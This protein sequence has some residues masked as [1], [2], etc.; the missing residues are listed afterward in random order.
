[1]TTDRLLRDRPWLLASLLIV[2]TFVAYQP[3]WHAGFV[4]DDD[5]WTT[6]ISVLLRDFS[7]LRRMWCQLSALQQYYPLSGTTFWLDYH[8]WSF[9]PLPYHLENVLLHAFAALLFWVLLRRLQSP[10]AWFAA[11]IFA[12]HP[13]MVES[14]AWVTERKNVLSLVLYLGAL[15]AYGRFTRFWNDEHNCAS[16]TEGVS[17]R[18]W[19]AY[20]L[21]LTLFSAAMLAKVTAFSLPPVLLL[22]G[23]WKRGRI[24]WREDV[25]PVLPFLALA[26]GLGL[27]I[28][29]LEWHQVGAIGSEWAIPFPERC[30]IA[31][32][33]F[34]F[35][36]GKLVWP[37]NL[38]FVYPRWE[39]DAGSWKQW[40]YPITAGATL[41]ALW[42]ARKRIGRGPAAAAL[43]FV[44]TLFPVLGFL[45]VYFMRFSFV[46]DHWTYLPSLG[47]IALAGALVARAAERCRVP[48]ALEGFAVVVLPVLA[49]LTWSQGHIYHDIETFWRDTLMKN[50]NAW[51]AHNNLGLALQE[52][53]NNL[54]AKMHYEEALR[55][56]PDYAD[57]HNNL[58]RV[59]VRLG[60][61]QEGIKHFEKA[62]QI[63]PGM[64]A[65]HF[66]L[67]VASEQAGRLQE[68]IGHYEQALRLSPDY[69]PA[70]NN[71]AN[72][73][74]EDGHL[75][76]AIEHYRR[77]VAADPQLETARNNLAVLLHRSQ[78]QKEVAPRR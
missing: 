40:L 3:V 16:S 14:V 27:L 29:W 55:L 70:H 53:G 10:G 34:W 25:V 58:G 33:V 9:R 26:L 15:L 41:V 59:L 17:Q 76:E 60:R 2:A 5:A 69:A 45:N 68:A 75:T 62:V 7:G 49:L 63:R 37:A 20:A 19:P 42:L 32:R 51:M 22:V 21:A 54:E 52:H 13:V 35:Y 46:S 50:P 67:G 8:L 4:W 72:L 56:K 11:A 77:A 65:A 38:C 1:V 73:L 47:L 24:R 30:L 78:D 61:L 74:A 6:G 23:W 39:L 44:G 71:L 57:A 48:M 18:D 64:V 43:F 31:G 12:L 28:A 36:I 66:N